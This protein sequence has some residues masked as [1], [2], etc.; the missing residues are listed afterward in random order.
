M[1]DR[2]MVIRLLR[3]DVGEERKILRR[4]KRRVYVFS[5]SFCLTRLSK[6]STDFFRVTIT[7]IGNLFVSG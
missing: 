2:C 7:V 3:R 4:E 6:R 1:E 5:L